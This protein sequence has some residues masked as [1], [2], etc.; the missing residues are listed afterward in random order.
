MDSITARLTEE[1]NRS[2]SVN[3]DTVNVLKE[4]LQIAYDTVGTGST[5]LEKITEND[6]SFRSMQQSLEDFILS[7][8]KVNESLTGL[9]LK[10]NYLAEEMGRLGKSLSEVKIPIPEKIETFPAGEYFS[11]DEKRDLEGTIKTLRSELVLTGE[12]VDAKDIEI[13][14]LKLSMSTVTEKLQQEEQ[15]AIQLKVDSDVLKHKLEEM[16]TKIREQL[17]RASVIARDQTKAR[18]EQQMHQLSRGKADLEIHVEKLQE[19]LRDAEKN[20][21]ISRHALFMTH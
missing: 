14:S 16:D 20:L 21:V 3:G 19:Q 11:I 13:E 9:G 12:S 1:T 7:V 15:R 4:Q 6:E 17:S 5:L 2:A 10:E 8:E 18:F